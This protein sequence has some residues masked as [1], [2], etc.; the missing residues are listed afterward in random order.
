MGEETDDEVHRWSVRRAA[1]ALDDAL[2]AGSH[3]L[4]FDSSGSNAS[5]LGRRIAAARRAGFCTELLWVDVPLE[6]ALLR[7]RDRATRGEQFC[8][9]HVVQ[10][11]SDKM[12]ASYEELSRRVESAERLQNWSKESGELAVAER[13]LHLYPAPQ[14]RPPALRPG[15]HG[16][17]EPSRG[18]RSPSRTCGSRRTLRVGPWKRTDAMVRRKGRRLAWMSRAYRGQRERFVLDKVLGQRDVLL[19]RNRFQYLLPP[20]IEHWTLWARHAMQHAELC[21]YVERWLE[22]QKESRV[23][24]WNYEDT[25]GKRSIDVWHV[26]VYFQ[27]EGGRPPTLTHW[28]REDGRSKTPSSS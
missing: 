22:Q 8:P 25:Q 15:D 5:W 18:A 4:V 21:E 11:K 20:G 16:Y 6:V 10:D 27:G 19:E 23:H 1:D 26:H 7:N 9:E 12:A 13:D 14:S 24:R 3:G 17:G 28:Q 2:D